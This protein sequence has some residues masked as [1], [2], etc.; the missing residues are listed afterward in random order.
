[1]SDDL[2]AVWEEA[3]PF[4]RYLRPDMDLYQ[5]W[6]GIYQRA[7]IPGWA[8]ERCMTSPVRRFLV[9]AADWCGDAANTIPVLGRLADLVPGLDL[10][11]VERDRYPALMDR[12]LTNGSRSIPIVIALDESARPLATWGPRPQVLQEWMLANL[13]MMPS[14]QRYAYARGWYARDRGE[15]LLRELLERLPG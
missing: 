2:P 12:Y 4:L 15:S 5:L 10:R 6:Q 13:K 7:L 11:L 3:T 9:I 8:L 14:P 1:M